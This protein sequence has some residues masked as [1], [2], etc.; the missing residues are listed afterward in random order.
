MSQLPDLEFECLGL[1][2]QCLTL[3][4]VLEAFEKEAIIKRRT[5]EE[6]IAKEKKKKD[7]H[8]AREKKK[9]D[10]RIA[11]E[12]KKEEKL[13][14]MAKR[15]QE[16]EA[17]RIAREKKKEGDRIAREKKKE[18]DRI[19]REKKKEDDRIARE[20]KKVDNRITQEKKREGERLDRAKRKRRKEIKRSTIMAFQNRDVAF[21][22]LEIL[23]KSYKPN[24]RIE[25]IRC[26][27]CGVFRNLFVEKFPNYLIRECEYCS[28]WWCGCCTTHFVNVDEHIH[29][30]AL[31]NKT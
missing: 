16:N 6:R 9:K 24:C 10:D 18:D 17:R 14:A 11:R 20:K 22:Q 19:A 5:E 1:V 28:Q 13:A 25:E 27:G 2:G 8:I 29:E 7:D 12:K 15:K 26:A 4:G 3:P 30:C 23:Y 31:R 21:A